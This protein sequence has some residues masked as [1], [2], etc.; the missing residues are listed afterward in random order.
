MV[1][2]ILLLS[3]QLFLFQSVITT[4]PLSNGI[5]NPFIETYSH[6]LIK[7]KIYKNYDS[8]KQF[9]LE[10]KNLLSEEEVKSLT[11]FGQ[12]YGEVSDQIL[13]NTKKVKK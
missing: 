9:L 7:P 13:K 4:T 5:I 6:P 1:S 10:D 11:E 8:K 2:F 12:V 3:N